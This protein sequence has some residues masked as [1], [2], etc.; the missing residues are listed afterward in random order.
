MQNI[1]KFLFATALILGL[2]STIA[3]GAHPMHHTDL[4]RDGH[5]DKAQ[6]VDTSNWL[7]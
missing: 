7:I 2:A 4:M 6:P 1:F 5:S 3:A